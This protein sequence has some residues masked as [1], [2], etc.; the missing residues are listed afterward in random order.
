MAK[1]QQDKNAPSGAGANPR[2]EEAV[3]NMVRRERRVEPR[4]KD[5]EVY[6]RLYK[7]AYVK[8]RPSVTGV[9]H[10]LAELRGGGSVTDGGDVDQG[11]MREK[12]RRSNWKQS[13]PLVPLGIQHAEG[14]K[15]KPIISPS[16]LASDW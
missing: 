8:I 1:Q 15:R 14:T 3:Q 10:A 7:E 5:M 9:F 4:P 12:K 6:D 16:L 11:N 2:V 13:R